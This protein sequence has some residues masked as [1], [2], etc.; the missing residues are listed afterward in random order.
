M[1]KILLL[2]LS[3]FSFLAAFAQVDTE[4]WFA[5]PHIC[6]HSRVTGGYH[7][8]LFS[9]DK[10][11][12]IELSMPA[13]SAFVTK[14]YDLNAYD[15]VDIEMAQDYDDAVANLEVPFDVVSQRGI[16]IT[17]TSK[18]GGYYNHTGNNAEAYSLKN[19]ALGT[20]FGVVSQTV[21]Q[22]Q[23]D[24]ETYED[25][26]SSAQIVATEDNT[27]VTITPVTG[28]PVSPNCNATP[29]VVHLNRGETYA[30]RSC[31]KDPLYGVNGMRISSN[32]PI[33]V[34]S[35]DD[36]TQ[37]GTGAAGL[38]LTGEQLV[39]LD[40]AGRRYTAIGQQNSWNSC[41]IT[42]LEN[43]TTVTLSTG[44][45]LNMQK[46]ETQNISMATVQALYIES[47]KDVLVYQITGEDDEAAGTMLPALDCTGSRYV[48]YKRMPDSYMTFLNIVTKSSN[49]NSIYINNS[50]VAS[51]QFHPVPGTGNAWYYAS[52]QKSGTDDFLTVE[53]KSGFIQLG[54]LDMKG[55]SLTDLKSCTYGYFSDYGTAHE[56]D[57]YALFDAGGIYTWP[58]HYKADG[59][60]PQIFNAGGIYKDTLTDKNGC[61]S[62]CV[63]HLSAKPYPDNV[64]VVECV[65]PPMPSDF[66][67]KELFKAEEAISVATP[68]VADIDG[69]GVTEII[70]SGWVGGSP[71]FH[72]NRIQVYNGRNGT[73]K[74]SITTPVYNLCG[75]PIAIADVD[76]DGKGEIFLLASDMYIYAYSWNGTLKWKSS[77]TLSDRFMPAL[78]DVNND[79]QAELVCGK[80]IFK[81]TDGTLLLQLNLE[82]NGMGFGAPNG[83]ATTRGYYSYYMPAL[84]DLDGDGTLELC[85]GNTIYKMTISNPNGTSGNTFSVLRTAGTISVYSDWNYDG[86]TFVVDFDND[87]D[88]DIC[89]IGCN[90]DVTDTS[91]PYYIDLYIWDGQTSNIIGYARETSLGQNNGGTWCAASMPFAGDLNGDGKPEILFSM[92]ETAMFAYTHDGSQASGVTRMHKHVP[93]AETVGFTV[94]DF[95]MDG[96]SEIVYRGMDELFVADGTTLN[97]LCTPIPIHSQTL[98]EYPV[99]ADVNGDGVAEIVIANS[100]A[101]TTYMGWLSVYGEVKSGS[102]SSARPV[103]NQWAYNSVNVNADLTIPQYQYGVASLYPNGTRPFNS[104]LA[105][106]PI[107]DQQG[108]IFVPAADAAVTSCNN[109]IQ[110]DSIEITVNFC[111]NGDAN[112]VAPFEVTTYKN[113]YRGEVIKTDTIYQTLTIGNC[114]SLTTKIPVDILCSNKEIQQ[115]LIAINDDGH[116]IAQHGN[117]QAECDTTNNSTSVSLPTDFRSDTT[118]YTPVICATELPYTFTPTGTIF[119]VGTTSG[120][121]IIPETNKYG[122]DSI[123]TIDLTINP[124]LYGDT[125]AVVYHA[126]TYEWY[127]E[128]FTTEGNYPHTLSSK[129]TGC[130]SIVTLHLTFVPY[131]DN[132]ADVEC[133]VPPMPSNFEMKE[134]F[135]TDG[136]HSMTTPMV[137]DL[138]GDGQSE[139]ICC[140]WPD[141]A[142]IFLSDGFL[143]INGQTGDVIDTILTCQYPICGQP[144][145]IADVNGDGRCEIFLSDIDNYVYCYDYQGNLLWNTTFALDGTY[146]PLLGNLTDDNI[147]ELLFGKY[148]FNPITGT[149]IH[150]ILFSSD[151]TGWGAPHGVGVAHRNYDPR[152]YHLGALSDVDHDGNLEYCAGKTIYKLNITN[153]NGQVGNSSSIYKQ[154]ESIASV[155]NY[156]GQTV[157]V[158]FDN[159]GIQ[160]T[161]TRWPFCRAFPT[162]C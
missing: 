102:W 112:L 95:N 70:S 133:V 69:D 105:Q 134:L 161:S 92:Y 31:S 89:V 97:Y 47:N 86:Q 151:G 118:K 64:A 27:I 128:T 53:C 100:S 23:S 11:A 140:K 5:V 7:M 6:E 41:S 154:A 61:D 73:L 138:D 19:E 71:K 126:N 122:C 153:P 2:A 39:S 49:I 150:E 10:P 109:S 75:Y 91:N 96:K 9:Y 45:V 55:T 139:I 66:D 48:A 14:T 20:N 145:T 38:D 119:P 18:I 30:V 131:P 78:A 15:Y 142:K 50:K 123:I 83:I 136:V 144:I 42:A 33:A 44:Q 43:G 132:V 34:C 54:V 56:Y 90:H 104:F 52:I 103:W 29:I 137:A 60:T 77:F 129:V 82:A 130:D 51:S 28:H 68:L 99:V 32:K 40:F 58:N 120:R 76:R 141:E 94:F 21:F 113:A 117:Q 59:I 24:S 46:D 81:A 13:N 116:G 135:K 62:I 63:L 108:D 1:R 37:A 147:P 72:A 101:R 35:T 121:T 110:N 67:M 22:I 3:I 124:I 79:G 8:V 146:I 162:T 25:A 57:E 85:A 149:L 106:N 98:T 12:H 93:F 127:G 155:H 115:L 159:D 160:A 125:F 65:V 143:V 88:E 26:Y 152:A 158:D 148:I 17:S 84:T 16:H 114:T 74:Q 87:G 36:S 111:N 156:D 157:V 80:Y 107:I 4:F